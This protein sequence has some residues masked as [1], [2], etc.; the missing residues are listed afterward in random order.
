MN[1][2]PS[3][4]CDHPT[5]TAREKVIKYL[6]PKTGDSYIKLQQQSHNLSI[7]QPLGIHTGYGCARVSSAPMVFKGSCSRDNTAIATLKESMEELLFQSWTI[8]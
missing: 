6:K 2:E 4:C 5:G 1:T 3:F 7:I 8:G